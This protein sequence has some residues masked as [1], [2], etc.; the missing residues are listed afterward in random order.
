MGSVAL[1]THEGNLRWSHVLEHARGPCCIVDR[2]DVLVLLNGD[3]LALKLWTAELLNLQDMHG[4]GGLRSSHKLLS[5][6]ESDGR[7][8]QK[9][10]ST[11]RC[12]TAA[13]AHRTEWPC[14]RE[15]R[16]CSA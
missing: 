14:E 3:C 9:K 6:D 12:S 2:N 16:T 8:W 5:F 7:T 13:M 11:S 10:A 15:H 1:C 4:V